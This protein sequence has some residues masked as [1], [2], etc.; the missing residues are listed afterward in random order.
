MYHIRFAPTYQDKRWQN[1]R[2]VDLSR[3]STSSS[4]IVSVYVVRSSNFFREKYPKKISQHIGM[5]DGNMCPS[6]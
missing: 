5:E 3:L 6:I 2:T 4:T 1:E